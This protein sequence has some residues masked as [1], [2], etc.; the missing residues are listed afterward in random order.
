MDSEEEFHKQ[1]DFVQLDE[2]FYQYHENVQKI[3]EIIFLFI[4]IMFI[5]YQR[6]YNE[7]FFDN[8]L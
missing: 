1:D 4:K 5:L 7:D 6:T 8:K 3:Y 2:K